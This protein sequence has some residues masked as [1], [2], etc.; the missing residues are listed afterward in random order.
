MGETVNIIGTSASTTID[1]IIVAQ[2]RVT[3]VPVQVKNISTIWNGEGSSFKS[4]VTGVLYQNGDFAALSTP[5]TSTLSNPEL[6]MVTS[7]FSQTT[8]SHSPSSPVLSPTS[9]VLAGKGAGSGLCAGATAGIAVGCAIVGLVIGVILAFFLFRRK[10]RRRPQSDYMA[11]QYHP[12]GK[13][14][15]V[16]ATPDKLQ[17]D[18]FLLDPKPD[19][20]ITSE[21]R[22]LGQLI[23]QHVENNYHLQPVQGN[24]NALAQ[25]LAD[26]GLVQQY[27]SAAVSLASLAL[28]PGTRWATLQHVISRVTFSSLA[29]DGPPPISLLPSFAGEFIRSLPP[30]EN[31]RGRS[32]G[33]SGVP[34]NLYSYFLNH[35]PAVK[36]ALTRWRQISAFL[37]HP[38]RSE[39]T[40][41][42]PSENIS[43]LQA[44]RLA[45]ALSRFL[46]EFIPGVR[47]N[48]YEQEN[49]LREVIVECATFGYLLFFQPSEFQFRYDGTSKT[50]GIMTCPGLD[51]ITTARAVDMPHHTC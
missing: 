26:L 4:P 48:R 41:L 32:E 25:A 29:L 35:W 2:S 50:K 15:P 37:L 46:K 45:E 43:T 44:Q 11:M 39:R 28:D 14:P 47:E 36:V 42:L 9:Q 18:Q 24:L 23:Q 34:S 49:H 12:Q 21:L 13:D 51:K 3:T 8:S 10:S 19:N 22:S 38:D 40:Q 33:E 31:Y 30:V 7:G 16:A 20:D 17:L 27:P 1:T 5:G 6:S